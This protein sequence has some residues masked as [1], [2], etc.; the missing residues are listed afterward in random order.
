MALV[1]LVGSTVLFPLIFRASTWACLFC[2]TTHEERLRVCRMFV[3]TEG[4]KLGQ[5]KDALTAAFEG[6]SDM[7]ISEET[8]LPDPG[9]WG[10]AGETLS[11]SKKKS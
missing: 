1:A 9:P 8:L 11:D 10:G 6:L 5:C 7:E 2:F 3:G 4:S